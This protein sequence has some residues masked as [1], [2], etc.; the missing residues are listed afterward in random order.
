VERASQVIFSLPTKNA[1]TQVEYFP[2]ISA[3][4][5]KEYQNYSKQV[6]II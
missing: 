1:A 6:T 5:L 2:G 3:G 4:L